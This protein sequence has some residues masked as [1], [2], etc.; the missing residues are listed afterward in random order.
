MSGSACEHLNEIAPE[1]ALGIADGEDRAWALEHLDRC[2]ACRAR[3]ERLA[4]LADELLLL[5][6]AVEPSAGFDGR[7]GEAISAPG[8][9]RR[10]FFRRRLLLPVTAAL[11]AAT[12][13]AAAVWF[14]LSDDRNLADAYRA[15]LAVAN[16]EYFDAAPMVLPGG[17][18]V[19]Y[20]Y[21]YQGRA[22]WVLAVVYEGVADD[23][24]ELEIV[25]RAGRQMPLRPISVVDGH[26]SAGGVTAVPYE[27]IA[28]VRLLDRG[29]REVA[30][31]DL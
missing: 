15:T 29:G 17:E 19:G 11:A 18:K 4:S 12:C 13:A 9:S 5:A 10:S 14:A 28:E 22:S 3:I 27:R 6:P 16:G 23:H 1:V 26:G 21:G 2:T 7:V 25:T 20:V 31:S 24:Y 30:D 8:S